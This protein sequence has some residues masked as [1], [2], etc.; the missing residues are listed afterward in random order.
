MK[1]PVDNAT[2][3]LSEREAWRSTTAPTWLGG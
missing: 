3:L 2:R 1:G